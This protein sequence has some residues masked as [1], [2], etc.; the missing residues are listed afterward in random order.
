MRI[1]NLEST[2]C[3]LQ[4]GYFEDKGMVLVN[5]VS[6]A[7]GCNRHVVMR[8][9]ETCEIRWDV[10]IHSAVDPIQYV[11]SCYSLGVTLGNIRYRDSE[12]NYEQKLVDGNG[13][14]ESPCGKR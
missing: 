10:Y 14:K 7:H 4:A 5:L 12:A 11:L 8:R 13:R 6:F 3:S 9:L 1:A 2:D